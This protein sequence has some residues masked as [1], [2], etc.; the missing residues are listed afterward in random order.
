MKHFAVVVVAA[1]LSASCSIPE[2]A[3]R[4]NPI[5]YTEKVFEKKARCAS[6]SLCAVF[7]VT[8]PVFTDLDTA[9]RRYIQQEINRKLSLV[10]PVD[11]PWTMEQIADDFINGYEAF[12]KEGLDFLS[13]WHYNAA[14]D[15]KTANDSLISLS[16]TTQYYTGGAHGGGATYFVN[17]NPK[18]HTKFTLDDL[19]SPGYQE[20]LRQAG[21]NAF[22]SARNVKPDESFS[23]RGFEFE[24]NTFHL[25][26]NYAFTEKGIEFFYNSYEIA[27][28]ALGPTRI[29]I[30]YEELQDFLR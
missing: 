5:P 7:K 21:E 13:S 17:L 4:V 15:V 12:Q 24:G 29:L 11:K 10:E 6:D 18:T 30:P 19:L 9:T 3:S 16:V 26:E 20:V 22:R 23:E 2:G 28:Y 8:Y 14:V 25:N 1:L 27:P